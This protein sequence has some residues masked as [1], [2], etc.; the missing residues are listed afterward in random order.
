MKAEPNRIKMV[1]VIKNI[2]GPFSIEPVR[3]ASQCNANLTGRSKKSV[4]PT[5]VRR[6]HKAINPDPALTSATESARR[7]HPIIS[8]PTPAERT[9]IPTVVSSNLSYVRIRQSTGKA[10]MEYATPVNN[11][12]CVNCTD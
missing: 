6:I 7:V 12:K 10:V 1:T 3:R 8:L 4:Q 9:T 2:V 5:H 11:M